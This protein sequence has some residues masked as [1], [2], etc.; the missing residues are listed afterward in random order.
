MLDIIKKKLLDGCSLTDHLHFQTNNYKEYLGNLIILLYEYNNNF[1]TLELAKILA[2]SLTRKDKELSLFLLS[3]EKYD[4][5]IIDKCCS[6]LDSK[7]EY[8]QLE[9][10]IK[11][12]TKNMLKLKKLKL[13]MAN[14]LKLYEGLD[15]SLSSSKIK[16]I[17]ENWINKL[18]SERLE[19][20]ALLYPPNLWKGIIRMFH[21]KPS[22]FQ[23][24]WF[25]K[26]I[27]MTEYPINSIVGAGKSLNS[28]NI[29][30]N[31]TKFK[32]PYDY[33]RLKHNDLLNE[34]VKQEIFIYTPLCDVIRYWHDFENEKIRQMTLD[35]LLNDE[36]VKMPYGELIKRIQMLNENENNKMIVNKLI[37][38][39]ENKLNNYKI[40]IEDPVV[41]FGDASGSMEMAIKTSSII[42]SIL[43]KI[44]NAR[45]HL[46]RDTDEIIDNPPKN[47]IDVLNSVERFQARDGTAPAASLYPY[48]ERKEVVKTFI[49][50][51]DEIENAP[52]NE[53]SFA[54]VYR[55]Y[56]EEVYPAK[57][58]FISFLNNNK[59]GQMVT[60]LK[61]HIPDIEKD[62][63]QFI[64][65]VNNPDLRKLDNLLNLLCIESGYY[66]D[67]YEK[68]IKYLGNNNNLDKHTI[69][70]ILNEASID[71]IIFKISI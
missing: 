6:I 25:T 28:E 55:K 8:N 19:Y 11:K 66:N 35:R 24:S 9:R 68:I 56:R 49:L 3:N 69:Q 22:D 34:D 16:F 27:I 54:N 32:L 51:T 50:V 46:F 57:L 58:V 62:I 2:V 52:Y 71:D 36:E 5:P 10:D 30:H 40:H 60:D 23:L 1:T 13:R 45:M 21:L 64:L 48:Y 37:S 39:A 15:M 67:K 61:H 31:I 26:Y 41:V 14:I 65:N 53:Q 38:I 42:T 4:L 33:L 44:C 17:K 20:M 43:V 12:I 47:V 29:V 59:D 7:R 63:I 18:S 70:D